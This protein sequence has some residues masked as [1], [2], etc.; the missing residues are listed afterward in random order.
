MKKSF[1]HKALT[2]VL[3]VLIAVMPAFGGMVPAMGAYKLGNDGIDPNPD[4]GLHNSYAW[5]AEM[6]AQTDGDYLWVGTNRDAGGGI[7]SLALATAEPAVKKAVYDATGIPEPSEDNKGKIYRYK[8]TSGPQWNEPQWELMYENPA[9][10]GYRKM[11]VFKGDLYVFAGLTNRNF[12]ALPENRYNYSVVYRFKPDFKKGD[13]PEAVLWENL[14]G[15]AMLEYFR[16]GCVYDDMLYAGTFDSK[17]YR[18]DGAGLASLTPQ[19]A[20]NTAT[21]DDK[22]AGWDLVCDLTLEP[23]FDG[24]ATARIW[25]II[26]FNGSLYAFVAGDGFRVYKIDLAGGAYTVAQIVGN[27]APDYPRGLGIYGHVAASPFLYTQVDED[28]GTETDYV[29][30]TTFA[31]GPS[32]LS[33]LAQGDVEG[34]FDLYC[35]ATIYRFDETDNWEVVVGDTT[36]AYVAYSYYGP[37]DHVG[38]SRAGFFPG[39]RFISGTNPSS[40]QYIWWMA[41]HE[42]KLYASTWDMGVFRDQMPTLFFYIFAQNYGAENTAGLITSA[43]AVYN[44][45]EALYQNINEQSENFS[46]AGEAVT[47]RLEQFAADILGMDW[48]MGD[49]GAQLEAL[50]QQLGADIAL[51]ALSAG[52]AID[53]ALVDEFMVAMYDFVAIAQTLNGDADFQAAVN[54]V[55]KAIQASALFIGDTSD[56]AGFDLFV[57]EDGVSFK[58]YTVTGFGNPSNYGGR[59]ILP[60]KYG[61]FV[62]TANP[63]GGCQVWRL[64]DMA[65]AL[66]A[67]PNRAVSAEIKKGEAVK[68]YVKS[69]GLAETEL[70]VTTNAGDSLEASAGLSQTLIAAKQYVSEVKRVP[71]LVYGGFKYQE[72]A[73][74]ELGVYL[75]EVTLTG[76]KAYDGA[77]EITIDAAGVQLKVTMNVK[78][79]EETPSKKGCKGC[80]GSASAVFA[81]LGLMVLAVAKKK[82][83]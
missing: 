10:S 49:I 44:A 15:V 41:E 2:A 7:I 63:F 83:F 60:T 58:P 61:V 79:T 75:Y 23:V 31:N 19:N 9:I 18:T 3:A 26:G 5:C 66:L 55:S 28:T 27:K 35:P 46:S 76:L 74:E 78:V 56:P 1:R 36:G 77:A 73:E 65:P 34:A 81:M 38:N 62:M 51:I 29:Y 39:N 82:K 17:I 4:V 12:S 14:T 21:A 80:N 22:R 50:V 30:V 8:M 71:G 53:T 69:F 33:T 25:D 47:A 43:M 67:D 59:V 13:A 42:G 52:S 70:A 54:A 40:N 20:P 11:L 6:F 72:T 48:L 57:S 37:L 16:A 32:F 68:F 45:F 64:A 24:G